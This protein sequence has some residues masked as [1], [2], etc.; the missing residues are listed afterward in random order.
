MY[1]GLFQCNCGK[2][3]SESGTPCMLADTGEYGTY[4]ATYE[5]GMSVI[6][7]YDK[8]PGNRYHT[9][10][11]NCDNCIHLAAFNEKET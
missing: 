2:V 10:D 3:V 1:C 11:R 7:D 4:C 6:E 9:V 8:T 5:C